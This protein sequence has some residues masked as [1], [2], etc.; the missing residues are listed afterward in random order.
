MVPGADKGILNCCY[1]LESSVFQLSNELVPMDSLNLGRGV[2]FPTF[3]FKTTSHLPNMQPLP[4]LTS[5]TSTIIHV[6]L[7]PVL[8]GYGTSPVRVRLLTC[9]CSDSVL[10]L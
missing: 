1:N 6:S 2:D 7:L 8:S 4:F 3:S 10:C 5:L 9:L